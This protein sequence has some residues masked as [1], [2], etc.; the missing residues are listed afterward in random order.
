MS[1]LLVLLVAG[2]LTAQAAEMPVPTTIEVA[3]RLCVPSAS[4]TLYV[5]KAQAARMFAAAGVEIQ[6]IS[7]SKAPSTSG[8]WRIAVDLLPQSPKDLQFAGPLA[9]AYP[10]QGQSIKIFYDRLQ[11]VDQHPSAALLAHV[12]VHEITHILQGFDRHSETGIMKGMWTT[13]DYYAMRWRPLL[14]TSNDVEFIRAGMAR[15]AQSS[16]VLS[17]NVAGKP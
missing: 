9:V 10:F 4:E 15:H 12:L 16:G 6:W 17:S 5:A 3:V 13:A 7:S 2:G 14:F 1:N 11:R 8:A